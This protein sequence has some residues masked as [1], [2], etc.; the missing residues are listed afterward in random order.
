[1]RTR[2]ILHLNSPLIF[3]A[4]GC[5]ELI[6]SIN[7][8]GKPARYVT[9]H[10]KKDLVCPPSGVD[11]RR[12]NKNGNWKGDNIKYRELHQWLNRNMPRIDL[13]EFCNKKKSYDLAN[14]TGVYNRDFKNWKYLCR[15]CHRLYDY[16][17]IKQA[18]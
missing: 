7:T 12:G 2:D 1:V 5:G 10:N 11:K 9:R 8:A 14:I 4:C 17:K 13:C 6:H 15:S 3:C 16:K 18:V